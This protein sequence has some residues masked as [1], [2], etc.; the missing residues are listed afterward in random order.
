[1][2]IFNILE[3][4]NSYVWGAGLISL[5]LFTGL[6][7]TVKLKFI[8]FRLIPFI[9]SQIKR[10]KHCCETGG[11][12]PLRT[13]CASL[14]TA[15]GTGNIIGVSSA[16][17]I[18][19]AGSVFW[20]W[21]SAFL[22]MS[23]VYA[24]NYLS[25]IF[26]EKNTAFPYSGPF[27][28]IEKGLGSKK[29]AVVFSVF[30]IAAS[31]GMGGMVQS[32]SVSLSICDCIEVKPTIIAF[33]IFLSVIIVINGGI[34]RISSATQ[35]IIPFLTAIY[36]LSACAVI[37]ICRQRLSQAFENIFS[38]ALNVSSAVGG[39]GGFSISKTV[40][41]G[42]RR[43]IFSN[44]AGLGS[45]PI[46]HGAVA[47]KS[48][49]V[50]GMWSVFEV[51]LDT[52]ICC[53]LTALVILVSGADSFSVASAFGCIFGK[54]SGLFIAISVS[55]FAFCTIIGWY[56]CGETSFK[57]IGGKNLKLYRFVFSV[58][59]ASGAILSLS[60]VWTLSDIFNGLMAFPNL[61]A[62]IL[63][64]PKVNRD[65]NMNNSKNVFD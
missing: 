4:I 29:L 24:E 28:Y 33:I 64:S 9:F 19:G 49:S 21:V 42:I 27:V 61:L 58:S 17:A 50:M 56:Y 65:S 31:F 62:L 12:S 38:D 55:L 23:L 52:I 41:I 18:G 59:A 22:G 35:V 53:T 44:E 46:M 3:Q 20:M 60:P 63:L 39:I 30:C 45:S 36:I 34:N 2:N 54:S 6:F 47:D 11:I 15:M 10:Q 7:Y 32:N 40:S 37:F 43:G 26:R 8:Q 57:Y 48:P 5:L 14:G 16:L 13:V 51:F 25:I 1:M